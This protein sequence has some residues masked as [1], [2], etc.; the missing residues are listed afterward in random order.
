MKNEENSQV[1]IECL[2]MNF[3]TDKGKIN[4]SQQ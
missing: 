2:A 1:Q 4:N 3:D